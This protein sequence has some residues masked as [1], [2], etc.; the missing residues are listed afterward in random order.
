MSQN[1]GIEWTDATWNPTRG[2][3]RISPGCLNCYAERQAI[4]QRNSGYVDLIS[5]VNG[6]PA[7]T[8][9]VRMSPEKTLLQPLK[10]K[11]PRKIFVDSMSDLFHESVSDEQ[12]EFVFGV[13][14]LASQ[15][16]FQVL[17]KRADRMRAWFAK[18]A[19]KSHAIEIENVGRGNVRSACWIDP[20][21]NVWLGVSVENQEYANKRIPDLLRTPAAVRFVSYEPALGPID[22][23]AIPTGKGNGEEYD[24]I[25]TMNVLN[26]ASVLAPHIH[27]V[28]VGG[29]SGPG[30]RPFDIH[31]ARTTVEQC[32]AAGVA[33]FVKQ[34]GAKP[35]DSKLIDIMG[36]DDKVHY[37]RP[38]GDPMIAEAEA[39]KGYWTRA[40]VL[41]LR[42]KKGGLMEEWQDG[43]RVRLFPEARP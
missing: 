32:K 31:W 27:W 11:K 34:L 17:T 23:T 36:P 41:R 4:R 7:W 43:L 30:A 42:D 28:I 10:W 16:K 40:S 24:P 22:F 21:P 14:R 3:S 37:R 29:E 2:C 12:I 33:C 5:T 9:Q 18:F 1:T 25:V 19:G 20:L 13:M 6:H 39:T 35:Y 8:G 26:R 15:H 38:P